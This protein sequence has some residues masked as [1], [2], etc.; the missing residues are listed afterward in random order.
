MLP[1]QLQLYYIKRD[2]LKE[3]EKRW[4]EPSFRSQVSIFLEENKEQGKI[5]MWQGVNAEAV[6]RTFWIAQGILEVSVLLES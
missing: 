4:L 6:L 2:V 1:V 3:A 5:C